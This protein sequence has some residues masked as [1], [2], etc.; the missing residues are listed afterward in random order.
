MGWELFVPIIVKEGLPF[1]IKLWEIWR[2]EPELNE[3]AIARLRELNKET[4]Q[5]VIDA[6]S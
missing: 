4:L 6:T 1:A 3:A 5:S 2:A